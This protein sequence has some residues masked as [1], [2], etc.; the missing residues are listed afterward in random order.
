MSERICDLNNAMP[1]ELKL[2]CDSRRD[3]CPHVGIL[4]HGDAEIAVCTKDQF[5]Y[6]GP[7]RE[8]PV[9]AMATESYMQHAGRGR[10]QVKPGPPSDILISEGGRNG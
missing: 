5:K 8:W 7:S 6:G 9:V 4:T 1:S 2:C 3:D 10:H